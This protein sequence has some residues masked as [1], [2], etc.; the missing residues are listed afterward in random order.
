M[1]CGGVF[2]LCCGVVVWCCVGDMWVMCCGVAVWVMCCGGVVW[3][4]CCGVLWCCSVGDVLWWCCVGDVLWCVVCC[5]VCCVTLKNPVCAFKT[6]ACVRSKRPRVYR[7]HAH[8]FY[9]CARVAG[10]HGDVLNVH[11]QAF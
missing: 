3:V 5:V 6:L 8:M 4:M 7:Q 11:T 1:C 9:T 2:G 10:T